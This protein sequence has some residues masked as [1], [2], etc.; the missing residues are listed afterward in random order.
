MIKDIFRDW[1][2]ILMLIFLFFSLV[3]IMPNP[4]NNGVMIRT[5]IKDS[6]AY[7]A[8]IQ[9]PKASSTL[10]SRERIISIN[11]V[12]IKTEQDYYSAIQ[13]LKPNITAQIQTSN[14]LYRVI[15]EVAFEDI[16]LNETRI[17]NITTEVFNETLNKTINIT[18]QKEITK[19]RVYYPEKPAYVGITVSQAPTTNLRKGL[20]LQGGTRVL[21]QPSGDENISTELLN[22]VVSVMEQR[23][24]KYGITDVVIQPVSDMYGNKFVR[25]E[26]AGATD[27][28]VRSL[29]ASQG[30]FE[31]KIGEKTVF[32]GGK[33]ITYVCQTA[34][35]AGIDPRAGCGASG[36][37]EAVCR[38]R[39][40]IALNPAAAQKQADISK[41]LPVV[42]DKGEPYLNETLDLFLDDSKMDSLNIGADLKGRAVTDIQISGSGTGRNIQE[43]RTNALLNMKKLQTVLLTGS[44]PVKLNI[45]QIDSISP[46]LGN[47]FITSILIMMFVTIAAVVLVIFLKYREARI[48]LPIAITMFSE[49]IIL[50]GFAALVRWNLDLA[51]IA[52]IIVAVGTGVD[53]QIVITDETLRGET[54]AMLGWKEKFKRA[55]F[56]IMASYFTAV[57]SMIPLLFTGAGLLKGFALT[58]IVGISIG[59]F[60]TRPAYAAV[61]EKVIKKKD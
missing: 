24:N 42:T 14:T 58:T 52:G 15:P 50:L 12:Q 5:V 57:V 16:T 26:I 25:V 13:Q 10:M 45:A 30:K 3:A 41:D 11:N 21:L 55:F 6:P 8:G 46:T 7:T 33:D 40:S 27:E 43:A 32:I 47:E 4:L 31:A 36:T 51:S 59:V 18:Q 35:C 53:S 17:E 23:L 60:I 29:V 38:F 39:F 34:E 61:I 56:V 20:D 37:N 19:E 48:T 9:S 28:E 2:V 54:N 44:L 22:N 49:V 1:R